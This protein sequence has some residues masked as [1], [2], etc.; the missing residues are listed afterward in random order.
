MKVVV[1][2]YGAMGQR[3]CDAIEKDPTTSLVGA[4]EPRVQLNKN[5]VFANLKDIKE[6]FDIIIDFSH[7]SNLAIITNFCVIH[8]L[9]LVICTTGFSEE[10]HK[11]IQAT[12]QK[13]PLLLATN[14]SQGVSLMN[15]LVKQAA[16]ALQD[17]FDIEII[18]KHHNQ[19]LD[20]PSGTANTLLEMIQSALSNTTTT[21]YGRSGLNKRSEQEIGMHSLRGGTIVGE[22]TVLFAGADEVLEIRHIAQS[23]NIFATG[24]IRAAHYLIQQQPGFYTMIDALGG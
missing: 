7:P 18:E 9:P 17:N 22:H 5:K 23:K 19:K 10:D 24:A 4:I 2:G 1:F 15:Q 8:Q 11:H 3:L 12:S 20:A 6:D 16:A 13:I 14:T 21:A